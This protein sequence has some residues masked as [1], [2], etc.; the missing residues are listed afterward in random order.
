MIERES[1]ELEAVEPLPESPRR[2]SDDTA[3][4]NRLG[5]GVRWS[6]IV[7]MIEQ[8]RLASEA[9]RNEAA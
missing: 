8:D 2:I 1:P 9:A 3:G 7:A 6:D 4:V 5:R